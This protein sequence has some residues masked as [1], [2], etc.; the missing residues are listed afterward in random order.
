MLGVSQTCIKPL[1]IGSRSVNCITINTDASFHPV[2][3]KGG[4]A[5]Y[6][7]CDLFKIQKG[8][9]FKKNPKTAMEAEMMCMANALYT[10]LSQ[11]ELPSTKW[12]VINSDCLF[13]FERIKRK[14]QDAIGK[15][16]AE[17]LRKV[18]LKTSYKDV[19]MPK[20]EF[21]HVK[22]HNGTPDARSWVNDWCDK[23]AKKWM[24]QS[25]SADC[26]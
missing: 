6:I 10:L 11:K 14:S 2:H 17:M 22:A 9:M 25:V 26:R 13:S 20:F 8:G 3:K 18:R 7:V 21:R 1:V 16:V 4:Y 15:Q 19:I 24:K 12:I 23:E 5:F